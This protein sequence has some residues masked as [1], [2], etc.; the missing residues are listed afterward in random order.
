MPPQTDKTLNPSDFA[1]HVHTYLRQFIQAADQK[2][3][4][5]LAAS[6]AVLGFLISSLKDNTHNHSFCSW[7]LGILGAVLLIVAGALAA[8]AVRPRQ[9]NV[10]V[11]L[12][13]WIG[14]REHAS[15]DEYV[16]AVYSGKND[17]LTKEILSHCYN[18][19]DILRR[20]Y[21]LLK[22]AV[23]FFIAGSLFT[24][25]FFAVSILQGHGYLDG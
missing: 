25:L 11:G 17:T 22:Q 7:L 3:G 13:P 24:I 8:W 10:N 9:N 14:I 5:T 4:F 6:G 18:L 23:N 2:A 21:A 1:C 16:S 12:V 15:A 20:K 19:S